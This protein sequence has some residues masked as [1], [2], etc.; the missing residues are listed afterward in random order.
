VK[1]PGSAV[2]LAKK[3][4]KQSVD[5]DFIGQVRDASG[6]LVGG[7]R[8]NITVNLNDADAAQIGRRYLQYDSVLTLMPG[9]YDLHFLAREN[10][11]GKMGTFETK[12][13]IPDLSAAKSLRVSSVV[14]SNQ[15]E[16]VSSAVGSADGNKKLLAAHPLVENGQKTVPSITRVFRGDQTLYVYGEV[17]DP[18]LD[19]ER[20][21]PDV[22]ANFA[23]LLGARIAARSGAVRVP[24]SAGQAAARPIHF[25]SEC[26][27]SNRPEIRILAEQYRSACGRRE[28]IG[29]APTVRG[30]DGGQ[31]P[32]NQKRTPQ[33]W[34]EAAASAVS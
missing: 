4:A 14:L 23:L 19:P 31:A 12:F 29:K 28:S 11:T 25:A 3:G 16:A 22:Q 7:V 2:G 21:I 30:T 32:Q 20:K 15:K 10:L 34:R 18:A 9:T 6:K 5:L 8:D 17:Y 27:R 24:D 1:I 33:L 26:D 13:T